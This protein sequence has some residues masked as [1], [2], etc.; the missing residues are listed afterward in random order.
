MKKFKLPKF[1]LF[2]G[3]PKKLQAT[4]AARRSPASDNY[5]EEEPKTNLSSAFIVVLVLHVVA[6]G[7]IYAFNSLRASRQPKVSRTSEAAASAAVPSLA[8]KPST[9]TPASENTPA[10]SAPAPVS[11]ATV[12]HVQSGDTL[13]KIA[14]LHGVSVADLEVANGIKAGVILRPNQVLAI[15]HAKTAPKSAPPAVVQ[16]SRKAAFLAAKEE[17]KPAVSA[18]RSYIVAKGDTPTSIAKRFGTTAT[19]LLALNK[20]DDPTKMKAGQTVKVPVKKN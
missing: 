2:S 4:T 8:A 1:A 5:Y 13:T 19:E 15:P 12:Y 3:K 20:I 10:K 18:T 9:P 11:K 7:G 6:V 17:S 14:A 16:D